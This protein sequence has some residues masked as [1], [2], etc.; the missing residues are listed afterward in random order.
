MDPIDLRMCEEAGV[1]LNNPRVTVVEDGW[2]GF[3]ISTSA[4]VT[5]VRHRQVPV[6]G[7]SNGP[8]LTFPGLDMATFGQPWTVT[9]GPERLVGARYG[10]MAEAVRAALRG[11]PW[12]RGWDKN[13]EPLMIDESAPPDTLT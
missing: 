2:V 13:L 8:E 4:G 6:E 11:W 7:V 3:D 5:Q 1:P 10:D 12:P 9:A